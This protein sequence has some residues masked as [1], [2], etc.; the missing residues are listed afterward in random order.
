MIVYPLDMRNCKLSFQSPIQVEEIGNTF[1]KKGFK[2][3]DL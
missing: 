3:S 1:S 2:L